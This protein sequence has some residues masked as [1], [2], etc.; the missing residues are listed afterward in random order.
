MC[1]TIL[2]ENTNDKLPSSK[3][4][5]QEMI[6]IITDTKLMAFDAWALCQ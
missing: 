5:I 1:D 2:G 4:K 3:T 6:P